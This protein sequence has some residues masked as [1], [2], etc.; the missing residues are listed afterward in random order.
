MNFEAVLRQR[1]FERFERFNGL[2]RIS[3][4]HYVLCLSCCRY[5]V[6]DALPRADTKA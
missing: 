1:L 3:C 6:T 2:T 5:N 4:L